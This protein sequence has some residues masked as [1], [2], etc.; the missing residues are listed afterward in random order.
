MLGAV[1]PA[2][3]FKENEMTVAELIEFLKQQP[4]DIQV[5]IE[6]Y[7]EQCLLEA[8]EIKVKE[9]CK[10]RPDGWIQHKRTDMELQTYLLFPGN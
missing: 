5:A 10:P 3:T 1:P 8:E 7:S 4:Q 6:M 2:P 9:M